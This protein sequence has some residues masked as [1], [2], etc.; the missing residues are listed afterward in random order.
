[1]QVFI[2]LPAGR[3]IVASRHL[4]QYVEH[5]STPTS[6]SA[7]LVFH[8]TIFAHDQRQDSIS[9]VGSAKLCN[10]QGEGSSC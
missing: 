3:T 2:H 7:N 10:H 9:L 8:I 5:F 4:F 1:M 6:I